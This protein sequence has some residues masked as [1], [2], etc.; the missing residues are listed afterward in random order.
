MIIANNATQQL[1]IL[2]ITNTEMLLI[3][4]ALTLQKDKKIS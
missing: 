4:I 2:R 1:K 3:N